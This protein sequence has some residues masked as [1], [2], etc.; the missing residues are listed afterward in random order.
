MQNLNYASGAQT[1]SEN[2]RCL[3]GIAEATENKLKIAQEGGLEVCLL[4]IKQEM[5]KEVEVLTDN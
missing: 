5:Q 2:L 3:L 4:V 1:I